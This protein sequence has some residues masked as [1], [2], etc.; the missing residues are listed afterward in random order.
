MYGFD[1]AN[2]R[3]WRQEQQAEGRVESAIDPGGVQRTLVLHWQEHCTECAPPE[4]YVSCPLYEARADQ[5]C[6]RFVYGIQ[7]NPSFSGLFPVGA[8]IRFRR[9]GKLEAVVGGTSVS[10]RAHRR[11][12]AADRGATGAARA[13]T[14]ALA[15]VDRKRRVS[16]GLAIA[17]DKI[18]SELPVSRDLAFDEFVIE[19][20]SFDDEPF[21]LVLEWVPTPG[22]LALRESFTVEP[23]ENVHRVA[24]ERFGS[25]KDGVGGWLRVYPDGDEEH[26]VVFTWLDFVRYRERPAPADLVKCVAWDLDGTL[27][28]G[29]LVEDG[30]DGRTLLP[31]IEQL[32][33]A[34]DERG[35]L[36][37]IVSKND[38]DDAWAVVQRLGLADYFL[39]PQISWGQKSVALRRVAESLN[40]GLDSLAFIDDSAFERAEVGEAMP[41]VRVYGVDDVASLLDRPELD[42][43]VTEAARGRREQYRTRLEREEAAETFAGDYLDFLRSCGLKLTVSE[44]LDATHVERCLELI[45]RSNQLNLSKRLYTREEFDVLLRTDGVLTLALEAED[46]FGRYGIIGFVAVDERGDV[47]SVRDYV[48][49]CRVAQKRVEHAFFGWLAA[50][51]RNHG[52][53]ALRAELVRSGRN[54]PLERV[55]HELP[56]TIVEDDGERALF[57]LDVTIPL[58]DDVVAV[59][60]LVAA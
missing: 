58:A 4:C 26:R 51:E 17:R 13:L 11:L 50:R 2:K 52:A 38:H 3:L 59:R 29:I 22:R 15:K 16:G 27:W 47:P 34:L 23:G 25:L 5:K 10:P 12:A 48:L 36:Q 42:V 57:E 39:Y 55:F 19:C 31:G 24:A 54:R 40:I 41:M 53:H 6:A 28:D 32:V 35:I 20:H 56:F 49:S 18:I 37:T 33:R 1:W 43:P 45:Q 9:W 7:P 46:R 14:S 44:P 30:A 8:D 21:R 60:D